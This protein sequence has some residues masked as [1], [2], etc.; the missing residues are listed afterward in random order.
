MEH[1]LSAAEQVLRHAGAPALR[2]STLLDQVRTVSGDRRVGTSDFRQL[3][4]GR[5]D[6][7]RVLDPWRGPWRR[8][9]S[10]P[11]QPGH[12]GEPW[13][14]AVRD[15]GDG[16]ECPG[17]SSVLDKAGESVRWL[18]LTLDAASARSVM[19]WTGLALEE[20]ACRRAFREA[21]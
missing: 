1:L 20:V 2:L 18:A 9:A 19:R 11:E 7:F 3:L 12:G 16:A 21:A 13:V 17:R 10:E 6:R 5:P 14:V 4:E 8:V 15:G